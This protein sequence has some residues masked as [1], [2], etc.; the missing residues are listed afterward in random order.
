MNEVVMV[1]A[2]EFNRLSNYYQGKI[3]ES[4]L[5]NKA[6]RLA[7]EQQLI[8]EDKSIPDSLAVRM[9]KPMALEQ[10]QLV[11]RVRTGTAQPASY[12]GTEEPEG[13]ADAPIERLL[14]DVIK[15]QAPE[16]IEIESPKKPTGKKKSLKKSTVKKQPYSPRPD[17]K[18][19]PSTSGYKPAGGYKTP[20]SSVIP[21]GLSPAAKKTLKELGWREG[22]DSPK[23]G[24]TGRKKLKKT[25]AEKL[26]EG[27]WEA[28]RKKLDYEEEDD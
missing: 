19:K 3:T 15:K 12:E 5:L 23:G 6:G 16:V 26:Q 17:K 13:M 21:K 28:W 18:P 22:D 20:A 7:A 25:E 2:D 4:A 9:V 24:A 8:L 27:F 11:K 14:K 10:S 1:P